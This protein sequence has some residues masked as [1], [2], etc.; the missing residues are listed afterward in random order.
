[1]NNEKHQKTTNKT[2]TPTE[3]SPINTQTFC[4]IAT[5]I[6]RAP[7]CC[8]KKDLRGILMEAANIWISVAMNIQQ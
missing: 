1:M 7:L 6:W 8:D 3:S 5:R 2:V 4:T